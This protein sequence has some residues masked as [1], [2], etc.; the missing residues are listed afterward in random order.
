MCRFWGL[1][2]RQKLYDPSFVDFGREGKHSERRPL[3]DMHHEK[4][5]GRNSYARR[6][7]LP[8]HSE[9]TYAQRGRAHFFRGSGSSVRCS[10]C[11]CGGVPA[12]SSRDFLGG[13]SRR[14]SDDGGR[15]RDLYGAQDATRMVAPASRKG[16][17]FLT[18]TLLTIRLLVDLLEGATGGEGNEPREADAP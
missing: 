4:R 2:K 11:S 17:V 18:K 5:S 8:L 6:Y 3:E 13:R 10:P 9:G 7:F 15:G 12:E 16:A 14:N 1:G